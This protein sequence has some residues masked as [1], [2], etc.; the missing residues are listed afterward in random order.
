MELSE[1]E[2]LMLVKKKGEIFK[3]TSEILTNYDPR[4]S[5]TE[6]V[7]K[8][9]QILSLLST[10]ESYAKPDR[11]LNNI[12]RYVMHLT[13]I[14]NTSGY[15]ASLSLQTFCIIVNSIKFD[16][17]KNVL[18]LHIPKIDLTIFKTEL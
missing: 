17:T 12:T 1:N 10:I 9:N 6:I 2:R 11:N 18:K 16:F 7:N 14:L 15:D 8:L 3:L 5:S 4:G 13:G